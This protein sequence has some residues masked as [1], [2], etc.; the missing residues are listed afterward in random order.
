MYSEK[1]R[2]I[3]KK[4][5]LFIKKD[6]EL[7]LSYP[8]KLIKK[9]GVKIKPKIKAGEIGSAYF[10]PELIRYSSGK[11]VNFILKKDEWQPLN[12]IYQNCNTFQ[13]QLLCSRKIYVIR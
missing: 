1:K 3:L 8:A 2:N 13:R 12:K 7:P 4:L 10:T 9:L 11:S 6:E 5:V